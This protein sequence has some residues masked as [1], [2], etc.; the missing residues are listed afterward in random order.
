MGWAGSAYR[1]PRTAPRALR[2]PRAGRTVGDVDQ[3]LHHGTQAPAL[4]RVARRGIGVEQTGL[5]DP[6]QDIVGQHGT[7]QDQG[8]G[9]ELS[10]G[11]P[12]HVQV[13]LELAMKLL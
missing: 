4:G 13:G 12:F 7:G 5:T 1:T 8:I 2:R 10:R 3:F 6:A 11:E 9:G